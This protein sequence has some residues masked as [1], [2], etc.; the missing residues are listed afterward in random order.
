MLSVS[1]VL[2]SG[3]WVHSGVSTR[4]RPERTTIGA[5]VEHSG[6]SATCSRMRAVSLSA[7]SLARS[8]K[9]SS[10]TKPAAGE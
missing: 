5:G 9:T 3:G 7:P 10:P 2:S 8:V 6:V 1:P 4:E